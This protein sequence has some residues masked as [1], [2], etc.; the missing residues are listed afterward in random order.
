MKNSNYF[1]EKLEHTF[2]PMDYLQQAKFSPDKYFLV[3]V[4]NGPAHLRK[5]KIEGAVE[6]P[7]LELEKHINEIP[8]DKIVVVYCWD[9]WCNTAAKAAVTLLEKNYEVKELVGGIAAW[10][11]MNFPLEAVTPE[12]VSAENCNC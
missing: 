2:S 3:D 11:T 8:T 6:I 12:S 1:T 7:Q 5:E 10:R 9:V 4:R